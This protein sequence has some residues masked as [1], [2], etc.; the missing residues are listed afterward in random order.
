M[1]LCAYRRSDG[2]W[3]GMIVPIAVLQLSSGKFT[4]FWKSLSNL[5]FLIKIICVVLMTTWPKMIS[6]DLWWGNLALPLCHGLHN[7]LTV[8]CFCVSDEL[9]LCPDG[10]YDVA[11]VWVWRCRADV[12]LKRHRLKRQET[13]PSTLWTQ[14]GLKSLLSL[15]FLHLFPLPFDF[16]LGGKSDRLCSSLSLC[17][18]SF[19]NIFIHLVFYRFSFCLGF[20]V[21][22]FLSALLALP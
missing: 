11:L 14:I 21:F 18:F 2:G 1:I 22:L 5:S 15:R 12:S 16:T 20:F 17:Y 4:G 10:N 13:S 6:S 8:T 7:D 19:W 9:H 3:T